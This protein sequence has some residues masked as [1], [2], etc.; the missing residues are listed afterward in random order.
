[1][2][3]KA[4]L[5]PGR[6]TRLRAESGAAMSIAWLMARPMQTDTWFWSI[7]S[8]EVAHERF[9]L[10]RAGRRE[11]Y[12]AVA[13]LQRRAGNAPEACVVQLQLALDLDNVIIGEQPRRQNRGVAHTQRPRVPRDFLRR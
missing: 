7:V 12:G 6:G 11:D 13:V 4:D 5:L 2:M 10:L 9:N 1:M 3:V 8:L